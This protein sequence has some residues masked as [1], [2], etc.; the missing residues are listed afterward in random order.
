MA[1]LSP[2]EQQSW[3]RIE[4]DFR[5][6]IGLRTVVG[7][8]ETHARRGAHTQ[9]RWPQVGSRSLLE[10]IGHAPAA[11]VRAGV[12]A[13]VLLGVGLLLAVPFA[14]LAPVGIA[15][16]ILAPFSVL[17]LVVTIGW[18]LTGARRRRRAHRSAAS[19]PPDRTR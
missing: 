17:A 6:D 1:V 15:A 4:H 19:P 18:A 16:G 8:L 11:G 10:I 14:G 2:S 3:Q 5:A 12:G 13:L 7:Q 9:P